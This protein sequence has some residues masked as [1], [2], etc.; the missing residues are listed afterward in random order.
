MILCLYQT[1]FSFDVLGF[2]F[3]VLGFSFDFLGGELRGENSEMSVDHE[4]PESQLKH[5]LFIDYLTHD[6]LLEPLRLIELLL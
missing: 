2:S 5:R 1:V 3:D 4:S 6:H